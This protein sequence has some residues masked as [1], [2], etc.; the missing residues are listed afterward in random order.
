LQQFGSSPNRKSRHVRRVAKNV[1]QPHQNMIKKLLSPSAVSHLSGLKTTSK[2]LA[3]LA[4]AGL[5]FITS[6]AFATVVVVDLTG[7]RT[8]DAGFPGALNTQQ[9]LNFAPNEQVVS[10]TFTN[11]SIQLSNGSF[12]EEFVIS[13]NQSSNSGDP[14]TFWDYRP[15]PGA[16][17]DPSTLG[18]IN[19]AFTSP[20]NQFA[21]GPFAL[22]ADGQLLLYVYETFN[23][24]G[25]AV[26]A[27]VLSG[28]LTITTQVPEPSTV[29]LACVGLG[30]VLIMLW[31]RRVAL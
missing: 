9:T 19:G 2:R 1:S 12:G 25:A 17:D 24:G 13:A 31:R 7:F 23:D 28:T 29:A 8:F 21:S 22:L 26:D 14:G 30:G 20:S 15:F 5:A 16:E 4:A 27:T 18:P 3:L 11:L 6:N 10:I